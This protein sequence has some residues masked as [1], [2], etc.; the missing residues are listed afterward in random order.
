MELLYDTPPKEV[1]E[2]DDNPKNIGK[3]P[4]T[5]KD[6]IEL[7][8]LVVEHGTKGWAKI[9]QQLGKSAKKCA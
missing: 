5:K 7:M 1:S 3:Q 8:E 4:W 9:A 2:C 6:D